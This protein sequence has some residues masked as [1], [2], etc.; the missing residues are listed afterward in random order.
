[1]HHT[2]HHSFLHFLQPP[3]I[4]YMSA[5]PF[6]LNLVFIIPETITWLSFDSIVSSFSSHLHAWSSGTVDFFAFEK[7]PFH[8]HLSSVLFP[9]HKT[10]YTKF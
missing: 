2:L 5:Q 10:H 8:H 3:T 6:R 1:M 7:R 9:A 4:F